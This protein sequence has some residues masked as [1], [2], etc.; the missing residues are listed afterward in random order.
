MVLANVL[1]E[2]AN[3]KDEGTCFGRYRSTAE[4]QISFQSDVVNY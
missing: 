2:V 3:T 4:Y 1:Y